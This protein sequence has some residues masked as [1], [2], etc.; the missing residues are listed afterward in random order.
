MITITKQ[1]RWLLYAMN[2]LAF[3]A[4]SMVNTQ[5]IPF[6]SKLGYTV[7]QRGYI[8]AANAVVAIV[9][10]FLF[11][12]LC[13]RFQKVKVFFLAAYLLLTASSFAMFLVEH[14]TFWYHL[15]TVALMGGMV[16][17]IMGLDETWMLEVDQENY[18]RLR[19][20][21]ALGLTIGSP[22]AGFLV[23]RFHYTSVLISLGIVSVILCWLIIKAKDAD[24]K[25]GERIKME[26]VQQLLK[27]RG[28]LLLVFIYLLVYMI[29]TADQYVV[30]DKMLD[31]GGNSTAVGIKW[32]LQSFMEVPLF[33]FSA[34]ILARFQT[35][36]LLY[37]GTL[38][39]GIK[40]LLYGIS[41]QPWMIILTAA[42][43]L[44][45]LP[46]I[47][48]TSKVLIKE[49]TPEKL[50]SSAQMFAM[51]VFIGV[52]GLITPL[53]TSYLSKAFGYD[54]T[55]YIVAAFSIIP[56]LLIFYYVHHFQKQKTEKKAG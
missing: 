4:I 30:I 36:T 41:F 17:V 13:D 10:Q 31:I 42:L 52:S 5:M 34:K 28:Y 51:A 8:L 22:I 29:G 43:Q 35:K 40:F 18:G 37:F 1:M 27:N 25:K 23:H 15:F 12:Y 9:G 3:F 14:Q 46:I 49:I 6:L 20:S 7:V 53:I 2:F 19:A 11:G 26:S 21:G 16:K 32:A 54:W 38:M 24:K 33:L 44:V 56:L 47:M 50:F 48:L 45:T 39:Y 55:L